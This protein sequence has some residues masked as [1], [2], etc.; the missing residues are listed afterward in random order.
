M[1]LSKVQR[2][3][4]RMLCS[5]NNVAAVER[6]LINMPRTVVNA[7]SFCE[8]IKVHD[9]L[10]RQ[11]AAR[12]MESLKVNLLDRKIKINK[13]LIKLLEKKQYDL[14]YEKAVKYEYLLDNTV[15]LNMYRS[16]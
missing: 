2:K 14:W 15:I 1:P 10:Y 6:V 12:C 3:L 7:E 13:Q 8:Q 11:V 5:Q 9:R 16:G 4:N